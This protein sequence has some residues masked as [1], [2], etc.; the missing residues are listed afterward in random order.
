MSPGNLELFDTRVAEIM[1]GEHWG[2]KGQMLTLPNDEHVEVAIKSCIP[3]PGDR[4][5]LI[6]LARY[7]NGVVVGEAHT[8][9]I[10]PKSQFWLDG[11]NH[12]RALC[13]NFERRNKRFPPAQ[14]SA[15]NISRLCDEEALGLGCAMMRLMIDVG[16]PTYDFRNPRGRQIVE[17]LQGGNAR[18][19][20]FVNAALRHAIAP[21]AE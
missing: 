19:P 12:A 2:V 9:P 6:G 7:E 18:N 16:G 20:I 3:K 5:L 21:A 17:R 8:Q 15:K 4:L 11:H 14:E 10:I 1:S 13:A